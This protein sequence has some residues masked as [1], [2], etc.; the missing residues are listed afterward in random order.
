VGGTY[1]ERALQKHQ[2][3]DIYQEPAPD[4]GLMTDECVVRE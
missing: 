1:H 4:E 2:I 3:I